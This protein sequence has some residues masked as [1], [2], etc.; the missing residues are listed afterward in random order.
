V[1][2][3]GM[4]SVFECSFAMLMFTNVCIQYICN[5]YVFSTFAMFN[6]LWNCPTQ[7]RKPF[8]NV[9]IRY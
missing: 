5:A 1:N 7:L 3:L 4:F 6:S 9:K 2:G 8:L